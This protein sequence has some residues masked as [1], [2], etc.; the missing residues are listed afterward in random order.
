LYPF[1]NDINSRKRDVN[2]IGNNDSVSGMVSASNLRTDVQNKRHA[3]A[4][5]PPDVA[6]D[7]TFRTV[8]RFPTARSDHAPKHPVPAR[9]FE[10]LC[11]LLEPICPAAWGGRPVLWPI[12]ADEMI[13]RTYITVQLTAMLAARSS[14][15][16]PFPVGNQFYYYNASVFATTIR[17]LMIVHD[18]E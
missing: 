9:R 8:L 10:L 14:L 3:H 11:R 2:A 16:L 7:R 15:E 18:N 4:T 1:S 6:I 5:L 12:W 13:H 17:A